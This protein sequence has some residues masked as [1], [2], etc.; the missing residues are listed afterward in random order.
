[1]GLFKVQIQVGDPEGQTFTHVE[2][3]VDTG[4]SITAM[5]GSILPLAYRA[6]KNDRL[7]PLWATR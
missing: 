5:P 4:A 6:R 3:L 7:A 2:A 1:M